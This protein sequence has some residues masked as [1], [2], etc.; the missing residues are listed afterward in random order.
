M[1]CKSFLIW[2][3]QGSPRERVWAD[4]VTRD[5][6][7]NTMG[8]DVML[9]Q[10]ASWTVGITI[11]RNFVMSGDNVLLEIYLSFGCLNTGHRA[12]K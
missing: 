5:G 6:V 7:H 1:E 11:Q 3:L 10:T 2:W 4:S 9:T 8:S 12:R